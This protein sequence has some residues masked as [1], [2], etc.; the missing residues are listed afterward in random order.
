[1]INP[2]SEIEY[3]VEVS[4]TLDPSS[5]NTGLDYYEAIGSPLNNGDGTETISVRLIEDIEAAPKQ[6]VRLNLKM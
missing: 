2:Y 3:I 1:L 4:E 6:F 5:W